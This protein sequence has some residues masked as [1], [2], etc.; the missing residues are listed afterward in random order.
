MGI[1]GGPK[2]DS[3]LSLSMGL[4][5]LLVGT[6]RVLPRKVWGGVQKN[7]RKKTQLWILRYIFLCLVDIIPFMPTALYTF[8]RYLDP[9]SH[10]QWNLLFQ[11]HEPTPQWPSPLHA[12]K[13]RLEAVKNLDT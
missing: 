1:P 2:L 9:G 11:I 10:C 8:S 13:V 7:H 5:L 3:M 4:G 12:E 6:H